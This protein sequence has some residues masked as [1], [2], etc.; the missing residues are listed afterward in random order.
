M[1]IWDVRPTVGMRLEILDKEDYD[2]YDCVVTRIEGGGIYV[3]RDDRVKEELADICCLQTSSEEE[4]ECE[5]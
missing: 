5:D 2:V 4:N 1:T 3:L